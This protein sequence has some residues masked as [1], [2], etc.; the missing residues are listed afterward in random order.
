MKNE[1]KFV[2]EREVRR[3]WRI[4][5]SISIRR[6]R[7][8]GAKKDCEKKRGDKSKRYTKMNFFALATTHMLIN[9]K[10][11]TNTHIIDNSVLYTH[12]EI[13]KTF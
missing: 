8:S 4:T 2:Y 9:K 10:R 3:R 13:N 11:Q 6:R 7:I 5:R 1:I 12:F